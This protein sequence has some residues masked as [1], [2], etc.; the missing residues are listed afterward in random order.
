MKTLYIQLAS[1]LAKEIETGNY[2]VGDKMPGIRSTS[3]NKRVSPSTAVAAYRQLELDGY[4]E[5]RPR[6]GFYVAQR[7]RRQV[8]EPEIKIHQNDKPK[9]VEGQKRVLQLISKIDNPGF[10]QFGAGVPATSLLPHK[11]LEK[12]LLH[13]SK[14]R[15]HINGYSLPVGEQSLRRQFA[16]RMAQV[17]CLVD[18]NSIIVTSGCQEAV[19]LSL[20]TITKPG[21]IVAVESPTFHGHLQSI[22]ALGLKAIEIPTHPRDGISLDALK[23][24]IEQWP[25]KACI[26]IPNF[27]NPIGSCMPDENKKQLTQ[28]CTKENI[29]IIEDDIY[30]DLNFSPQRPSTL[31]SFDRSG[32]V[33][34]CSSFSKTISPG[35]RIGWVCSEKYTDKLEYEKFVTNVS[36]PALQQLALADFLKSGVYDKHLRFFRGELDKTTQLISDRICQKF[37]A[38]TKMT[39]PSGGYFLWLELPPKV[40]TLALAEQ[41]LKYKISIAPGPIFSAKAKYHNCMRVSCAVVWNDNTRKAIDTLGLLIQEMLDHS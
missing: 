12:A 32:N 40:D 10:I 2:C 30:G 23:L 31:K 34:Y 41:A 39:S 38:E 8:A 36:S 13:A 37:P 6:S 4:I 28:L 5:S 25:I 7:K 22:D 3:T 27:S 14:Q 24:A 1:E 29:V 21:D 18:E 16:R 26:L 20:K 19:L 35:M 15:H 9:L 11:A 17:G 33:I